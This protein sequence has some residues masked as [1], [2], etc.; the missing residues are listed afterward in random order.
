MAKRIELDEEEIVRLYVE[1]KW[2]V[3][4]LAKKFNVEATTIRRRLH[5]NNVKLRQSNELN[6]KYT[7]NEAY[8]DK[9]DTKEKAYLLGLISA[10]G[11]V[12]KSS[13][14]SNLSLMGLCFQERDVELIEFAIKELESNQT[15]KIKNDSVSVN[16]CSKRMCE[17]LFTYGIVPN[18]SLVLNIGEVINRASIPEDLI[19]SFLIGY[20][21]GDGSIASVRH[22]KYP[23]TIMWSC[24]FTGTWETCQFLLDYF[25]VGHIIDEHSKSGKTYTYKSSGINRV[26]EV[27]SPLYEAHN[28]FCL[29]RKY[30]KFLVMKSRLK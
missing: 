30:D 16:F 24:G 11:W 18:K 8:F 6:R 23:S 4:D 13:R 21:D 7:L 20:F 19:P 1:E 9:I 27:L 29:S 3:K 28:S 14:S 5:K 12:A 10:D 22:S 15:F 17:T 2:R 26:N 25:K